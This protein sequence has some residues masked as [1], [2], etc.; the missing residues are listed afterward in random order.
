MALVEAAD[1]EINALIPSYD[2]QAFF[3]PLDTWV[4]WSNLAGIRSSKADSKPKHNNSLVLNVLQGQG[5]F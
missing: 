3:A 1:L 4:R 5:A 2:S